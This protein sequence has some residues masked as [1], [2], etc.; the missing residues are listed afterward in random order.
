MADEKP[1]DVGEADQAR[2]DARLL[3]GERAAENAFERTHQPAFDTVGVVGDRAP[4]E[5]GMAVLEIEENGA[6]QSGLLAFQRHQSRPAVADHA[7]RGIGR[8][9]IDAAEC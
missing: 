2:L 5:I 1:D 4:A 8:A 3:V 9:E 7:H 6:W